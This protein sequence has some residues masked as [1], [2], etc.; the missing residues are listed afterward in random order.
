VR[1]PVL[2]ASQAW[3]ERQYAGEVCAIN[4]HSTI[5]RDSAAIVSEFRRHSPYPPYHPPVTDVLAGDD[6]SVWLRLASESDAVTWIALG[7]DGR[8][9]GRA[10]VPADFFPSFADESGIWGVRRT[11]P[12][13]LDVLVVTAGPPP[14]AEPRIVEPEPQAPRQ[15]T[16]HPCRHD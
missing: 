2:P 8:E 7:R 4:E 1:V 11:A 3:V 5:L 13:R 15:I 10:T 12:D 9:R 14:L 16:L 6:G